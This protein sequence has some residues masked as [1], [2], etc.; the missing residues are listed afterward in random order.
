MN[1]TD[2]HPHVNGQI[3]ILNWKLASQSSYN[4]LE[5]QENWPIY[6]SQHKYDYSTWI[7]RAIGAS[8]S[9]SCSNANLHWTSSSKEYLVWPLPY[10][11]HVTLSLIVQQLSL[12]KI[13]EMKLTV[14]FNLACMNMRDKTLL[15]W[16]WSHK[17]SPRLYRKSL[18]IFHLDLP[19]NS[20]RLSSWLVENRTSSNGNILV[21]MRFWNY[22]P[23]PYYLMKMAFLIMYLFA[24]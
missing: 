14:T 10:M 6:D 22:V 20:I 17:T 16:S 1:K 9:K 2:L 11:N 15:R 12:C 23:I 8:N 3:E 19:L 4:E 18:L 13:G 5:D 24:A 7:D 21:Q